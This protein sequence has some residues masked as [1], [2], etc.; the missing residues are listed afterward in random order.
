MAFADGAITRIEAL[1]GIVLAK[2]GAAWRASHGV[3]R[4]PDPPSADGLNHAHYKGCPGDDFI[5]DADS[6]PTA[7]RRRASPMAENSDR[8]SVR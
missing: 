3:G 2:D 7:R 8:P 4:R 5:D 1:T 6:A